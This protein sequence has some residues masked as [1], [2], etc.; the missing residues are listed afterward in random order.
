MWKKLFLLQY[1]RG[2]PPQQEVW[3]FGMVDTSQQPA[4]GFMQIVQRRDAATLLPIIQAHINPGTEIH[5][6]QW[7][8]YGNVGTLPGVA[9]HSTVNHSLEFVAADGTHTQH[10]ESYWNRVK[11]KLKRMKGCHAHQLPSYLD[12]FMWRE[13]NGCQTRMAYV[14]IMRDI[15]TQYPV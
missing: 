8:A 11:G 14:N 6:D 7:A 15:A 12:E 4:L 2:R 5:S 9:A 1:H 10:V 3:V 13:R